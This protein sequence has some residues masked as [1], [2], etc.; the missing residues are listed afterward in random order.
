[1]DTICENDFADGV[2]LGSYDHLCSAIWYKRWHR[3]VQFGRQAFAD[4]MHVPRPRYNW[5]A[6][7]SCILGE[8]DRRIVELRHLGK[9][10]RG[11]LEVALVCQFH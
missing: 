3:F 1:M 5:L 9:E 11:I 4:S 10:L 7:G 8:T 6:N 2:L